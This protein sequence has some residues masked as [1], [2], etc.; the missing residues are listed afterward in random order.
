MVRE[1]YNLSRKLIRKI[2]WRLLEEMKPSDNA[3][4]EHSPINLTGENAL[5]YKHIREFMMLKKK[6]LL[7]EKDCVK[8]YSKVTN[9]EVELVE[10]NFKDDKVKE[11]ALQ[12]LSSFEHI[13]SYIGYL[14]KINRVPRP[15]NI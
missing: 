7:L 3:E 6:G 10:A 14:Y 2:S 12:S 8:G 11:L 5:N 13:R 15:S 1:E 9:S 4:G